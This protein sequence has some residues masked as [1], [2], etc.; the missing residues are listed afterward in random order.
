M[1]YT[2]CAVVIFPM[3]RLRNEYKHEIKDYISGVDHKEG[4]EEIYLFSKKSKDSFCNVWV[5][6]IYIES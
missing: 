1:L 2:L 5:H 6:V 3:G 4:I